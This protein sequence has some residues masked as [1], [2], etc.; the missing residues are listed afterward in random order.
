MEESDDEWWTPLFEPPRALVSD[1]EPLDWLRELIGQPRALVSDEESDWLRELIGQPHV[2]QPEG[3]SPGV[4]SARHGHRPEAGTRQAPRCA[5]RSHSR[6]PRA[7][8]R[9]EL[10][11]GEGRR[12]RRPEAGPRQAPRCAPGC[13]SRSPRA[14]RLRELDHRDFRLDDE[15][16]QGCRRDMLE[17]HRHMTERLRGMSAFGSDGVVECIDGDGASFSARRLRE[18]ARAVILHVDSI[19]AQRG[20]CIFKIGIT[21]DPVFRMCNPR[22]GYAV[23][24]EIYTLMSVVF[25]SYPSVC[26]LM[27]RALIC[28]FGARAGCRNTAG[29]GENPPEEGL[30]YV[31][32]V[33][34]PCGHGR[35]LVVR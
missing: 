35:G 18:A 20:I 26:C 28:H 16:L 34:E 10:D 3:A 8:C 13:R 19:L 17:R 24:G 29:G 30:C 5:S 23:R 22:F 32:V 31:Y 11:D 7:V 33:S 21:R 14:M 15:D 12:S 1:E 2:Q 6:S 4:A 27:E 9:R 25:A